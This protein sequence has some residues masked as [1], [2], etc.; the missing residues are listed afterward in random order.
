LTNALRMILCLLLLL[1]T[2]AA[3][4]EDVKT[5]KTSEKE[6][7]AAWAGLALRPIGPA[8]TGGRVGDIAVDPTD[9]TIWYV[10]VASGGVWKTTNAGTTW[11]PVFDGEGSYS[12]GCISIDPQNPAVIW[13]GTGENN[14]QRSVSYGDGVYKS[15]DGGRSW[16]RMGLAKSEHIG[17][18][19]IDPRDSNTV[20][21]AA[22]GPLWA[23]GGDRGLY[24]TTDGGKTW[25]A[26]LSISK[27]TGVTDI[28]LDPRDPDVVYAAAWQRRRHVWTYLGGG[29]ESALYKSTDGGATWKKLTSG[30]P[31]AELGRIGL[32]IA[33]TRPDWVY[34]IVEAGDGAG[35]VFRSTNRGATW[36]KRSSKE[37]SAAQ[38]Y[39]KISVDPEDPERVYSL[40]VYV[41]V[42]DDGGRT[43]RHLGESWKHVDNHALWI[44]PSD[45]R[46]YLVG[47]DGGLYESFDRA[48]SWR[49]HPSLPTIQFYKI[50]L[51]ESRPFYRVYGGTQDNHTMGG[52]ARTRS[53]HGITN[54]DWEI[55]I[56]GD[57]FQP[58]VD[59][60][61]PNIVYAQAQYGSLQRLDRSNGDV[62]YIQPQEGKGE[63]PLR[64]NWDAPLLISPH[65]PARLWLA[66]NR[67]FRS[68]D[69]GQS[70]QIVGG[71][72]TRQLDRNKLPVMGR[73]WSV[74]AVA[75]HQ[76][77]S[78][79]GN[80]VALD[81][82]PRVGGLLYLGTD[83]GL[84]QVSEDGGATWRRVERVP[85]VPDQTYVA[86][87]LASQ[88]DAGTVYA[89]FDNHQNGDFK[90][91]LLKST[92]RGRTWTSITGGL[93]ADQTVYSLAEDHEDPSLLF[94]GTEFGLYFTQDGG[95]QWHRL[96][97]GLPTIQV[98]DLAIQKRENDLV[99]ATF[100]RGIWVLDDYSPLRHGKPERL[101][102]EGFLFPVKPALL[103]GPTEELGY[104][105]K[106]FQGDAFFTAPNPQ[107][108]AVFTWYLRDEVKTRKAT[109]QEQEKELVERGEPIVTPAAEELQAEA[110]ETDPVLVFTIAEADGTLLRRLTAPATQGVHR[111]T[112][113][114]RW[115]P[116][117]PASET[118]A[119]EDPGNAYVYIPQGP[120]VA[121]GTYRVS[122]SRI[123]GGQETSL[124]EP[125]T[126]EVRALFETAPGTG[127]DRAAR[128][129]FARQVARLQRAALGTLRTT[130]ELGERIALLQRAA[131]DTPGLDPSVDGE[132]R[133]LEAR[134]RDLQRTLAGDSVLAAYNE[135]TPSAV[136]DR[137][138][139][140]TYRWMLAAP[141]T[142]T[143]RE[144]YDIAAA[145][146]K[147]ALEALQGV[148]GDLKKIED[149]ME[150]AGAPW[151]PGRR[152][153]LPQPQ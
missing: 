85:G 64:W 47:C 102:E 113:D 152:P 136:Y 41:E 94:A 89:A 54:R 86:K 69:R 55:L 138:S 39:S 110:A 134:L 104:R 44:D 46:H 12:I 70:W 82:S 144:A 50:A 114:L 145:E 87:L 119:Q 100:G 80:A 73:L 28:V 78:L 107:S 42:S 91:Y 99:V 81:E 52:P 137:L 67:L 48:A 60:T 36:E 141:P 20:W 24:K 19:A 147:T 53:K 83:D 11:T 130:G 96:R 123:A 112:W 122:L 16:T 4:K 18:I 90:P 153:V 132:L 126:F 131:L 38:Y 105:G 127:A 101:R 124:G 63:P 129:E 3:A 51:D 72:L 109:R 98:R 65:D 2:A 49:F 84:V 95:R 21:V 128:Q 29:P 74:D 116:A 77:T 92:D 1:P 32:A 108:G 25:K 56:T 133:A 103:Y 79:Y 33:P 34:A 143:Q 37:N 15:E 17:R 149:R 93:P 140:L 62:A 118:T 57:G 71:D 7:A 121:P 10:A 151:T 148:E 26:V 150:A 88:H 61:N 142:Q 115:P 27:E 135:P 8:M 35:G 125:Q 22:Q 31:S 23:S 75:K 6:P 59:P 68:D 76:S 13:V 14:A 40:D 58:R 97:G 146:L 120:R 139:A 117:D 43:F 111:I 106:A 66:S 5:K 30:L 45:T 9:R